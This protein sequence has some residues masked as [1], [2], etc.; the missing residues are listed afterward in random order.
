MH[1][2]IDTVIAGCT[3]ALGASFVAASVAAAQPTPGSAAPFK[4]VGHEPEWTLD[5]GGNRL[6]LVTD[7]GAT[8]AELPL[9]A[10]TRIDGG[11]RY[12][13]RGEAN[14]VSVTILD[15]TCTDSMTGMPRPATVEVTVGGR[16][17]KGCG[18]DPTAVLRGGIWF[19]EQ[20]RGG[21]IVE[22]SRITLTFGANG[23][24]S[25]SAS[26][27]TYS[28]GYVLTGEGVTITMPIASMRS[29][30]AP[31]MAQEAEFLETLRGVNRYELS[32]DGLLTLHAIDGGTITA[33]RQVQTPGTP[34]NPPKPR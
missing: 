24:I 26:C 10:A 15:R 21:P 29:C 32:A 14:A 30:E 3:I 5:I 18:G 8:R 22:M 4:A 1:R 12:D 7:L 23:R 2:H 28:A 19:V 16:T 13:A 9:P 11:R 6:V 34:K 17:L 31:Y 25:G 27:N 20:L 33:R